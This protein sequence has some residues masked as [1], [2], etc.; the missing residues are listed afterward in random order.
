MST[1]KDKIIKNICTALNCSEAE[2]STPEPMPGGLSNDLYKFTAP[3]GTY[4]YRDPGSGINEFV[5]RTNEMFCNELGAEKGFDST[6]VYIS[7]DEGWKIS[8]LQDNARYPDYKNP[9]DSKAVADLLRRLH[10][11]PEKT[12]R[13][14]RPVEMANEL[15]KKI[16]KL[17]PHSLIQYRELKESVACCYLETAG[18]GV[19]ECFCH[20]DFY[21]PNILISDDKID[22]IDWEYAGMADP[23]IDVGY[24][25]ADAGYTVDEAEEFIRLYLGD[26]ADEKKIAHFKTY[27]AVIAYFWFI[28]ALY[29]KVSGHEV[30]EFEE[31]WRKA[32]EQFSQIEL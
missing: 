27:T 14:F 15:E 12:G 29:R 13:R 8:H 7:P 31:R 25:I 26:K 2:V 5:D 32:A 22:I 19:E 4:V 16:E 3:G 23:G 24:Y 10:S 11:L 21:G 18:D 20:G 9:E 17:A 28:W 1:S 30:G 6:M